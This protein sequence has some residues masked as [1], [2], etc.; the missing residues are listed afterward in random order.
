MDEVPFLGVDD[1]EDQGRGHGLA[2]QLQSH[3]GGRG[4][5]LVAACSGTGLWLR[6]RRGGEAKRLEQRFPI[7]AASPATEQEKVGAS[8]QAALARYE[9]GSKQSAE[10]LNEAVGL[11]GSGGV[12]PQ[13][14]LKDST[15]PDLRKR[16]LA[17]VLASVTARADELR[18]DP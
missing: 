18:N 17:V 4:R 12:P 9:K 6:G 3:H 1:A 2:V 15:S 5:G 14:Y 8:F 10:G 7:D 13:V 16:F 11:I